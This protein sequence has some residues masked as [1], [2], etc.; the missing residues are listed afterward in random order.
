MLDWREIDPRRLASYWLAKVAAGIEDYY[1]GEGEAEGEWHGH[2]AKAL[3]LGGQIQPDELTA[4]LRSEHGELKSMSNRVGPGSSP[5]SGGTTT[6]R[7]RPG[8]DFCFRAPKS[9]SLIYAF[10]G[11]HASREVVA[12]HD[13]AVKAALDYAEARLLRTR[14]MIDGERRHVRGDGLIAALFRHRSSRAGDPLL[15]THAL[16]VNA[17]RD[18]RGKWLR[19][20]APWL[21]GGSKTLSYLY[22]ATLRAELTR[23]LGVEWE[24]VRNGIADVRGISREAIEAFSRRR[25]QILELLDARG[26]APDQP[27]AAQQ[28]AYDT[29]VAK[30]PAQD[31]TK[32]RERWERQAEE[33]GFEQCEVES[34]LGRRPDAKPVT[35]EHLRE[36]AEQLTTGQ[37]LVAE[38]SSATE[39]EIIRAICERL[40]DGADVDSVEECQAMVLAS[41][42]LVRLDPPELPERVTELRPEG[43]HY[44]TRSLLA[45]EREVVEAAIEGR[46]SGT[47]VTPEGRLR[48]VL[49]EPEFSTLRAEQ[50][51][52][53]RRLATGGDLVSVVRGDAGTGKTF[54]LGA[55]RR[56]MAASGWR[57][58]GAA[59]TRRAAAELGEVGIPA[60]SIVATLADIRRHPELGLGPRTVLVLDEAGT[61][62]TWEV[63]E[64][65]REVKRCAG[66]LVLVGDPHQLGAIGPGGAFRAL[67]ER[68][69]PIEL[70]E[71]V[72]QEL[73]AD[74]EA[75]AAQKAGRFGEALGVYAAEGRV[76]VTESAFLT[77]AAV[78][79]GWARD[80]DPEG[81]LML[82]RSNREVSYLNRAARARLA[83]S[84]LLTGEAVE[85]AGEPFQRGDLVTTRARAYGI[86]VRNQDRWRVLSVD[87]RAGAL[88]LE[89]LTDD[90]R[91][92]ID[93]EYLASCGWGRVPAIQHGYAGTIA[94]AQ[95]ATVERVHLLLDGGLDARDVY[96]ATTRSRGETRLYLTDARISE[97]SEVQPE[98]DRDRTDPYES[99]LRAVERT[100]P[101]LSAEAERHRQRARRLTDAE[102]RERE[103]EFVAERRGGAPQDRRPPGAALSGRRAELAAIRAEAAARAR[104]ELAVARRLQPAWVT[105]SLG[106][107]PEGGRERRIWERRLAEVVAY[108]RRF[109]VRDQELRLGDAEGSQARLAARA[110]LASRLDQPGSPSHETAISGPPPQSERA[111]A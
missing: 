14:R 46:G 30:E 104:A 32:L 11:K 38:A 64:L 74:R 79:E 105:Q 40:P 61:A 26:Q 65:L 49:S 92:R 75:I 93:S 71:V 17:T 5:Y 62:S 84:G 91:A 95:G 90:H 106:P 42:E 50:R 35:K 111:L 4:V 88:E 98:P 2:G 76:E 3:G 70:R 77:R 86:G 99:A 81:S 87:P 59:S 100:A 24:P 31:R 13:A 12:A 34:A 29:R 73:E 101:E 9:V 108:R 37:G 52:M 72:R 16:V 55:Y 68:L 48:A 33:V 51:A 109:G 53:V 107:M 36:I 96:T 82:A 41:P 47:A 58:V 85:V 43:A 1:A 69:Q 60:T 102:L 8:W 80:A 63:R 66:K 10:G 45:A 20:N 15:H 78:I 83:E 18:D 94:I 89:R 23:R 27:R 21:L 54:V 6:A 97:R 110:R 39:Q 57:V 7:R 67:L 28:A 22:Q 25:A 44:T 19:I 56:V 103:A